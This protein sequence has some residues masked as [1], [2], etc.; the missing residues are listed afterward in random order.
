MVGWE[1]YESESG[2]YAS[3]MMQRTV[4][5]ERCFRH[6]LVLHSD[7]GSPMK[8]YTLQSKLAD[9]GITPSHS[10]LRVSNDNAFSESLFKTIKYC[11][12]WPSQRFATLEAARAWM[13]DFV[14]WYNEAHCHSQINFV[15]P[16]Q[17]HRGE[18]KVILEK[19]HLVYQ[20]ARAQR[21]ERWSGETRNW[22][23]VGE[24]TLNPEKGP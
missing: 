5:A 20:R 7:N 11:P 3:E 24:V 22:E 14:Q 6:P 18:D 1:V 12:Q 13:V 19:R 10:R 17:R 23:P 9:L 4:I 2:A 21:P 16:G 8:S 15:T